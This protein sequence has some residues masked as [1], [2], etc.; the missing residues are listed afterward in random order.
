MFSYKKMSWCLQGKDSQLLR[1]QEYGFE[2]L[3]LREFEEQLLLKSLSLFSFI[4]HQ[5]PI[6]HLPDPKGI[7]LV[8]S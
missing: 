3:Q 2:M 5:C 6:W 7:K 4:P 1:K 8:R